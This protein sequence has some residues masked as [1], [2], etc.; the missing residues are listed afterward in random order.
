MCVLKLYLWLVWILIYLWLVRILNLIYVLWCAMFMYVY[1]VC[2]IDLIA[3][4]HD[5]HLITLL[6]GTPHIA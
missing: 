4:P 3:S 6:L 2:D 5:Y 1:V